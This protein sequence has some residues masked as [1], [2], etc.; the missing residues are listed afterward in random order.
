[1]ESMLKPTRS[2]PSIRAAGCRIF[3]ISSQGLWT[4]GTVADVPVPFVYSRRLGNIG[5]ARRRRHYHVTVAEAAEQWFFE[6]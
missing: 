3:E 2:E 1:M 6:E 5:V 4:I